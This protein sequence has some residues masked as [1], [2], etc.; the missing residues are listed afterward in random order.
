MQA[1]NR[2]VY[3]RM[4]IGVIR[5]VYVE[6]VKKSYVNRQKGTCKRIVLIH[7]VF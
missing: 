3:G 7:E 6:F 1:D 5:T 4:N 2:G